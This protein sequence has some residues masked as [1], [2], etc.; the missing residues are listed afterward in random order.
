MAEEAVGHIRLSPDTND[1]PHTYQ[2]KTPTDGHNLPPPIESNADALCTHPK[3]KNKAQYKNEIAN[4]L[5]Q[6]KTEPAENPT[7]VQS[8]D[9][10]QK[11]TVT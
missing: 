8:Q 5:S 7:S 10:G 4:S 11:C 1:P 3:S 2:G 9:P 6:K